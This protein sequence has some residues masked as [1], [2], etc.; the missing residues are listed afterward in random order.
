MGDSKKP[1]DNQATGQLRYVCLSFEGSGDSP[2]KDWLTIGGPVF[3]AKG[4]SHLD[5]VS[6][7]SKMD[8]SPE[9]QGGRAKAASEPPNE[10]EAPF[11]VVTSKKGKRSKQVAAPMDWAKETETASSSKSQE[12]ESL[13]LGEVLNLALR[14]PK[15]EQERLVAALGFQPR[16]W[17][18]PSYAAAASSGATASAG[19]SATV[20]ATSTR[21]YGGKSFG[22]VQSQ[23]K[24][25]G[26]HQSGPFVGTP[27]SIKD[28]TDLNRELRKKHLGGIDYRQWDKTRYTWNPLTCRVTKRLPKQEKPD[29]VAASAAV[30]SAVADLREFNTQYGIDPNNPPVEGDP[31]YADHQKMLATLAK[32]KA[33]KKNLSDTGVSDTGD[34]A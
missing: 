22:G 12:G 29:K 32:A 17:D 31:L 13:S 28:K 4:T 26:W 14:L 20:V 8:I 6:E 5:E 15:A 1:S 33:D 19:R 3:K 23:P 25:L 27:L 11:Q 24:E 16:R 30:V 34:Q 18:E 10:G 9:L 7:V 21:T 2:P